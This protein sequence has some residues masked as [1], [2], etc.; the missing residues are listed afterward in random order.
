MR[1]AIEDD[2]RAAGF[3]PP[4]ICTPEELTDDEHE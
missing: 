4:V 1:H 2:C 3:D